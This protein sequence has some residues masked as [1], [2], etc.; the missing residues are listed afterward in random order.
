MPP[1]EGLAR[2][3]S[4]PP[5]PG[6]LPPDTA[7]NL[8]GAKAAIRR[9]DTPLSSLPPGAAGRRTEIHK[10]TSVKIDQVTVQTQAQDA[11]G[12][13]RDIGAALENKLRDLAE[14]YDDGVSS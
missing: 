14:Q 10:S 11:E 4:A 7:A 13:S 2:P 1:R 6:R 9:T 8:A 12:I 5:M 3:V